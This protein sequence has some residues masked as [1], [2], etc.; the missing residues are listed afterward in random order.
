MDKIDK[1]IQTKL[2]LGE[3]LTDSRAVARF[4]EGINM[5][6]KCERCQEK[7]TGTEHG[8]VPPPEDWLEA[9]EQCQDCEVVEWYKEHT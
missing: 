9:H 8:K 3:G 5:T 2:N 6:R 4:L 7:I 1:I